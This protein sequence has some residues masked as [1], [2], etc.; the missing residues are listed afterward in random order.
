MA[1]SLV[2]LAASVAWSTAAAQQ[3]GTRG[4]ANTTPAPVSADPEP[5]ARIVRLDAVVVDPKGRPILD[6]KPADFEIVESGVA[7]RIDAAELRNA[8]A[9]GQARAAGDAEPPIE[10]PEDERRAAR[11]PGTRLLALVLDEFHVNAGADSD[12]VREV[13]TRFV[14]EQLRPSD[15]L[16]VIKPL[17]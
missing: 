15:L 10:S 7:Q 13:V 2:V 4:A 5:T 1:T 8:K 6:L 3:S 16:A 11:E 17:D 14:D 9:A 12:R